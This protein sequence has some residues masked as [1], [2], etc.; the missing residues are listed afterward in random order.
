MNAAVFKA[1]YLPGLED[2]EVTWHRLSLGTAQSPL[3]VELPQLSP[4]QMTALAQRVQQ[5]SRLH[6]KTM[7][8]S[9][10]VRVLDK[11]TARL[12]DSQGPVPTTARTPAA[13]GHWL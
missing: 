5:A 10:I 1:A 9:D 11:A 4:V 3:W 2:A 7:A 8:V 6:L 12:L 13:P